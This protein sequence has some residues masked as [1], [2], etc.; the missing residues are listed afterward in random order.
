MITKLARS[1]HDGVIVKVNA[2]LKT[3]LDFFLMVRVFLFLTVFPPSIMDTLTYGSAREERE[4]GR[5]REGEREGGRE[6]E[7]SLDFLGVHY[8]TQ[9][10]PC[11]IS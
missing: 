5:E 6:G 10:S 7:F 2:S 8:R 3:G 4:G 9:F 11:G 1:R